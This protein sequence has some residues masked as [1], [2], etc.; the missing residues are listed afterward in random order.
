VPERTAEIHDAAAEAFKQAM[1]VAYPLAALFVVGAAVLAWRY[2]PARAA[3]HV[4]PAPMPHAD[5]VAGS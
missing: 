2:L 1:H 5:L 3:D 4:E